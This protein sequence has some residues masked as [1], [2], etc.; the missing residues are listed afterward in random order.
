MIVLRRRGGEQREQSRAGG[1]Q[2]KPIQKG[3]NFYE[4]R[5]KNDR[6][7]A[8]KL[9]IRYAAVHTTKAIG[10]NLPK[11][12]KIISAFHQSGSAFITETDIVS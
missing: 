6:R 8:E 1:K 4:N 12:Q 11:E 9:V 7:T 2:N 10:F 5:T 3:Q